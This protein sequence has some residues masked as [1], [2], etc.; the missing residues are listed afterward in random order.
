MNRNPLNNLDKAAEPREAFKDALW[1]RLDA[2]LEEVHM[3]KRPWYVRFAM[4]VAAVVGVLGGAGTYA[5]ASPSVTPASSL[6]PVKTGIEW[7]EGHLHRSTKAEA[8]FHQRM[9]ERRAAEL[10]RVHQPEIEAVLR[11]RVIER[12]DL[13]QERCDS[14]DDHPEVRDRLNERAAEVRIKHQDVLQLDLPM[15]PQDAPPELLPL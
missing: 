11:A 7:M 3:H 13:S 14:L 10:E 8:V 1:L 2:A 4:P 15:N 5:Y 6:Y 12:L 9:A